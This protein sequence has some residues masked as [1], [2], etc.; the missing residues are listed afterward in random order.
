MTISGQLHSPS[1]R[2]VVLSLQELAE[3]IGHTDPAHTSSDSDE[4]QSL[5]SALLAANAES[6]SIPNLIA[7]PEAQCLEAARRLLAHLAHDPA[8]R[9]QEVL[10]DRP[11]DEQMSVQT[12]ITGAVLGALIA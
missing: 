1:D 4:A 6:A 7:M 8:A 5:L 2:S 12:A 10:A 11:A 9:T 3:D